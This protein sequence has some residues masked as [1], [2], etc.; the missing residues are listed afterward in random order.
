MKPRPIPVYRCFVVCPPVVVVALMVATVCQGAMPAPTAQ[1]RGWFHRGTKPPIT[2]R[3]NRPTTNQTV[4]SQDASANPD[5]PSRLAPDTPAMS[6][7]APADASTAATSS[8]QPTPSSANPAASSPSPDPIATYNAAVVE[9]Q[10]PTASDDSRVMPPNN[11]LVPSSAGPAAANNTSP[12]TSPAPTANTGSAL[13][14]SNTAKEVVV[15]IQSK[16]LEYDEAR[17]LYIASGL[18]HV[19]I[20]EQNAEL[21]ADR[22]I[23]DQVN[24]VLIAE[25]NVRIIRQGEETQGKYARIDLTR[26]SALIDDVETKVEA[27]RIKAER[28]FVNQDFVE[29]Q[30]GKLIL[31]RDMLVSGLQRSQRLTQNGVSLAQATSA[32]PS[33]VLRTGYQ[34]HDLTMISAVNFADADYTNAAS[35]Q[36]QAF[37]RYYQANGVELDTQALQGKSTSPWDLKV[38]DLEVHQFPDK[39]Q[40]VTLKWPQLTF[41]TV[42]VLTVPG[43][44]FGMSQKSGRFDYLGPKMGYDPDLGGAHAGPGLNMHL[45]PGSLKISPLATYGTRISRGSNGSFV[46]KDPTIGAG[47]SG[48][49]TDDHTILQ[50]SRSTQNNYT[51]LFAQRKIFDGRTRLIASMNTTYMGGLL[52]GMERPAYGVQIAD[53]RPLWQG[54]RFTLLNYASA[55]YFKDEFNPTNLSTFFFDKPPNEPPVQGRLLSQVLFLNNKP[56]IRLGQ[57]LDIGFVAQMYNALYTGGDYYN[58]MRAGP[59][60]NLH[61]GDRFLSQAYLSKASINGETPFVFDGFIYGKESLSLNNALRVNKFLSVG[62]RQDLDLGRDNAKS[63]L[64]VGNIVYLTV[65]PPDVKL[66]IGFDVIRRTTYFGVNFYPSTGSNAVKFDHG[67]I[68]RPQPYFSAPLPIPTPELLNGNMD[69]TTA[70]AG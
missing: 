52:S 27:V 23:Y 26:K 19:V 3:S 44:D 37:I 4:S 35:A 49:Y 59:T 42:P 25:G 13:P 24:E 38:K 2:S 70:P 5:P 62:A 67:E 66:N 36:Q 15:D 40:V 10:T 60:A 17:S 33:T 55:G 29:M 45:G 1:A 6:S 8:A 18:V 39:Y 48:I 30:N 7:S 9:A 50:G 20:S 46:A 64:M 22:V 56:L 34:P 58:V 41:K 16:T 43:V 47:I 61:L 51:S 32:A 57:Y 53:Q 21:V 12:T 14:P 54:N 68:F 69:P 63:D 11:P 65:G 31:S 28:A